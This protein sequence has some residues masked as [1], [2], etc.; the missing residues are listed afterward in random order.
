MTVG[1]RL[2][3][4][5]EI[6]AV[7][8]DLW[9]RSVIG[10]S[11]SGPGWLMP[12]AA[13]YGTGTAE[14]PDGCLTAVGDPHAVA[15][16]V[17]LLLAERAEPP[18]LLTVPRGTQVEGAET[19][20]A[21]W[22]VLSLHHA[23]PLLPAEGQVVPVAGE[24]SAEITALLTAASPEHSVRPGAPDVELWAGVRDTNGALI[25]GGAMVRKPGAALCSLASIATAPAY[26]GQGLAAGVTAWLARQALEREPSGCLLA[27]DSANHGAKRV[28]ERL[29]FRTVREF[30]TL[31]FDVW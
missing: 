23:P 1:T 4:G 13:C 26:R 16:L 21:Q 30:S 11:W 22:E 2:C 20:A 25:C 31:E 27:L 19:A 24:P 8:D 7:T 6:L 10:P 28:Y 15:D 3:T 12:G 29:G 9:T 5:A 17:R 18:Y 14:E